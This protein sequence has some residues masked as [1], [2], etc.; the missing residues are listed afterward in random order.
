MQEI[1]S[2]GGIVKL[3]DIEGVGSRCTPSGQV[4]PPLAVSVAR[5]LATV[6][7]EQRITVYDLLDSEE[8]DDEDDDEEAAAEGPEGDAESGLS[9]SCDADIDGM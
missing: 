1:V 2:N 4:N 9:E 8:G 5:G 6:C 3:E 7:A